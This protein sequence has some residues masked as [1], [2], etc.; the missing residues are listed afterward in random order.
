MKKQFQ[1]PKSER[2]NE[3]NKNIADTRA[4]YNINY[5]TW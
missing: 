1:L 3:I 5:G 2:K 4:E